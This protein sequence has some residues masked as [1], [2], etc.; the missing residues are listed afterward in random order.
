MTSIGLAPPAWPRSER[1]YAPSERRRLAELDRRGAHLAQLHQ[2]SA[3]VTEAATLVSA[4]WVQHAWF[5]VR[6]EDSRERLV[7]P[8]NVAALA[9]R[10]VVGVC[11]AGAIVQAGGGLAAARTQPVQRALDLTWHTLYDSANRPVRWC[12]APAARAMNLRDLTR[13]NDCPQRTAPEVSALL[14]ATARAAVAQTRLA[15]AC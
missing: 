8:L 5:A 9:G 10:P 15:T 1:R 13:W 14:A 6:D 3:I 12:P 4:G 11:L 2:I 7:G